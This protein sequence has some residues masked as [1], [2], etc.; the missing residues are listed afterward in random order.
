MTLFERLETRLNQSVKARMANTVALIDGVPVAGVFSNGYGT[1]AMVAGSTPH[2]QCLASDLAGDP[3]GLPVVIRG[4]TY[5][6]DDH[7]PDGSGWITLDLT[8]A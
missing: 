8:E 1:A 5:T 6:I 3:R 4:V 7:Q 2:F